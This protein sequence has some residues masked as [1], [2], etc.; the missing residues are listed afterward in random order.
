MIKFI[1]PVVIAISLLISSCGQTGGLYLPDKV[2]ASNQGNNQQ[3][4]G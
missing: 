4:E 2:P 3:Q 1:I